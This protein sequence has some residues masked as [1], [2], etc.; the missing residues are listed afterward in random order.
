[1]SQK[2][3]N[4]ELECDD[5]PKPAKRACRRVRYQRVTCPNG[6]NCQIM[7]QQ[8]WEEEHDH[9]M[10][11]TD[12]SGLSAPSGSDES[13]ADRSKDYSPQKSISVTQQPVTTVSDH[14]SNKDDNHNKDDSTD[15]DEDV[16]PA[17]HNKEDDQAVI[18]ADE[19]EDEDV[20]HAPG[21]Q[22]MGAPQTV[23]GNSNSFDVSSTKQVQQQHDDD[24][25]HLSPLLVENNVHNADLPSTERISQ[26]SNQKEEATSSA[27][28][29][30]RNMNEED[31]D[32]EEFIASQQQITNYFAQD[33]NHNTKHNDKGMVTITVP[34]GSIHLDQESIS[35]SLSTI[36]KRISRCYLQLTWKILEHQFKSLKIRWEPFC[37]DC[38]LFGAM[39][40]DLLCEK[41]NWSETTKVLVTY[42]YGKNKDTWHAHAH[43]QSA[44]NQEFKFKNYDQ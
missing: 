25:S 11:P 6:S 24:L 31:D 44:D 3:R 30:H 39:V 29:D 14:E 37:Q 19:D 15:E 12:E 7:G 2:K 27:K 20:I 26:P 5:N 35:T 13:N 10:T 32:K 23:V 18:H 17:P 16:L 1:M 41:M 22:T 21:A 36:N 33:N 38:R 9:D 42:E 43:F 8:H 34:E 40:R 4:N 28:R